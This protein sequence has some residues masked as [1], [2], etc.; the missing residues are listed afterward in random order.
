MYKPFLLLTAPRILL[1]DIEQEKPVL[2]P[3]YARNQ[4]ENRY[5]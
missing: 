5:L 1:T 3:F 4:S 2:C